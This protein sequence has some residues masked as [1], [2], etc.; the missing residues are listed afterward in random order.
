M[1]F[2]LSCRESWLAWRCA[3]GRGNWSSCAERQGEMKRGAAT[4]AALRPRAAA[5]E[6]D[7]LPDDG[8]PEAGA[9]DVAAAAAFDACVTIEDVLQRLGRES[10]AVIVDRHMPQTAATTG[11]VWESSTG[12]VRRSK[13]AA[14]SWASSGAV[15][16]SPTS[17]TR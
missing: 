2:L 4:E 8:E 16:T 15:S 12:R 17:D 13:L 11:V 5:V 14:L 7:D 3:L 1:A 6:V 10:E 9:L